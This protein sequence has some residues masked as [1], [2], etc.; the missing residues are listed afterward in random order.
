MWHFGTFAPRRPRLLDKDLFKWKEAQVS[1]LVLGGA[2]FGK[3]AQRAVDELLNVAAECGIQRIDTAPGYPD[4]EKRI[5]K[6]LARNHEFQVNTKVGQPDPSQFN[7]P[8]IKSSVE[9]SLR[10]LGIEQ[11]ETLFIH[12]L[13]AAYLTDENIGALIA[14]KKQGKIARVGY[15]GDGEDLLAALRHKEFDDFMMTFN[16][17][18]QSNSE[19]FSIV[20]GAKNFYFK[21][22]LA[23]AIWRSQRLDRRLASLKMARKLWGKPPLPDS[24]LDYRMRF[25]KFKGH[26]ESKDY[27][28]EFLEFALFSEP[29]SHYVVIGTTSL[30]HIKNAVEVESQYRDRDEISRYRA[31][32]MELQ[33]GSWKPHN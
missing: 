7:P 3:I 10:D 24:W 4:S 13:S 33:S 1:R 14:L 30:Q 31:L 20:E 28:T 11:I 27:A 5:G 29:A 15:S 23:Q 19:A 32:W 6:F 12:S 21:I 8:G 25:G 22:P 18:D 26:L 2:S 17:I 16:I 9:R